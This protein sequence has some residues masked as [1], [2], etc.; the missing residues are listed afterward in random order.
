MTTEPAFSGTTPVAHWYRRL[1]ELQRPQRSLSDDERAA[2]NDAI[3]QATTAL[4]RQPA[5][6]LADIECKLAVL[7]ARLRSEEYAPLSPG[8]ALTV[9]LGE[10]VRDDIGRIAIGY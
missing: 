10:A 4:M 9:L 7:C 2:R 5:E 6:T 3:F 8:G 1:L